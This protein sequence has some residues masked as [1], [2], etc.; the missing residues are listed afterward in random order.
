MEKEGKENKFPGQVT[1]VIYVGIDNGLNGGIVAIDNNQEV[2]DKMVMPTI[3][4]KR[5]EFD[6]RQ[7]IIFF[8]NLMARFDKIYVVLEKSHVRPVSGKVACFTT[9]FGYGM[10]QGILGTLKIS[11]EIVGPKVWQRKLLKDLSGDTKEASIMFC[12]HK[13]PEEDWTPTERSRKAH[14]GL[15][16]AA[17][18][19]I[20]CYRLNR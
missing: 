7:I 15:T 4:L 9:G 12:K 13:W 17:A 5:R 8:R 14:D 20:Y 19:A 2:V 18:M 1:K 10:F 6:V 3:K 16:D 11:Y